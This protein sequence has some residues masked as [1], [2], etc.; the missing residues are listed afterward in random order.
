MC[1]QSLDGDAMARVEERLGFEVVRGSSGRGGLQ[2]IVDMIDRVQESPGLNAC[3]AIDGSRGPRGRAQGGII[4]LA[5]RTGGSLLPVA[6]SA[7]PAW[8]FRKAWDRTLL[9]LPFSRVEVVFGEPFTVPARLRAPE[10][11]HWR[12]E[13]EERMV[14]LQERADAL[15]GLVDDAPIRAPLLAREG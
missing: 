1:S 4:A 3:L 14:A 8:I 2:A 12:S 10:M 6:A 15:A 13:L 7:R 11:E 5:Q 9:P